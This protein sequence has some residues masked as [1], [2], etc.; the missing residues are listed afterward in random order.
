MG[1]VLDGIMLIELF[2]ENK[3]ESKTKIRNCRTGDE[4]WYDDKFFMFWRGESG[5]CLSVSEFMRDDFEIL[6]EENE[7]I[8]IDI[9]IDSIEEVKFAETDTDVY[10]VL[11]HHEDRINKLI[12]AVKQLNK[13]LEEK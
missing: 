5:T 9:D 2:R 10:E 6:S 7:E 3:M 8:E 1:K 4:Y 13:K 12:K 11:L